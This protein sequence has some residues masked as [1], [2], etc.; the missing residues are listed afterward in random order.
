ME[1]AKKMVIVPPELISRLQHQSST[2]THRASNSRL[3]E[4]MHRILND[5]SL[6]DN[7][8]WKHY[9]QVLHRHLQVTAHQRT[10]INLP[11][12][13]TESSTDD[14][15]HR[16]SSALVD[17]IVD[18][19]PKTYKQTARNLLKAMTRRSDIINWDSDGAVFVRNEKIPSSNIVD[20][21]HSIVKIRKM[22][23]KP[24]GWDHVMSAIKEMNIPREYINNEAALQF[25]GYKSRLQD[26]MS[27]YTFSRPNVSLLQSTPLANRLRSRAQGAHLDVSPIPQWESFTPRVKR[28]LSQ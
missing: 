20:I 28:T 4:E 9:Q 13:D 6:G 26:V 10:P 3:D 24:A 19:F 25:L 21:L 23:D 27:S 7:E 1:Y 5:K 12:V 17:E 11:I 18:S 2:D 22:T 14:G 8:K 16:T 15:M